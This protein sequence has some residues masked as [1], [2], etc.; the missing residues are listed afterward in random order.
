MTARARVSPLGLLLL[1][2][3]VAAAAW[4][5]LRLGQGGGDDADYTTRGPVSAGAGAGVAAFSVRT[6]G[7][8]V[9]PLAGAGHPTVVMVSSETCTYCDQALRDL[10]RLAGGRPLP[11]L[12]VVTIEGAARGRP[13]VEAAGVR[14][15]VLAGPVTPAAE[16]QFAFQIRGTPTWLALDARGRVTRTMLGYPG[17]AVLPAWLG[18]MTGARDAP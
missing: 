9:I 18:V 16:A 1:A 11:R 8:D 14:G 3:V 5:G 15:A 7:G 17:E 2:A 12:R 10:G 4:L 13:M 6:L